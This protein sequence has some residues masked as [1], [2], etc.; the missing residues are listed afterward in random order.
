MLIHHM[1]LKIDTR[2]KHN[3]FAGLTTRVGTWVVCLLEVLLLKTK[4]IGHW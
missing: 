2:T 1:G 3:K 4:M